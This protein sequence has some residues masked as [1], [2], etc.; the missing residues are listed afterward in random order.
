MAKELEKQN[1]NAVFIGHVDHGKSTLVGRL[2]YE[3][4]Q[5]DKSVIDRYK[6]EAEKAGKATFEYAWVMDDLKEERER[7][8]TIRAQI[9]EFSTS[10][11]K[12][13]ISDAP[14]HKDFISNM[15]RGSRQAD[16]AVIVVSAKEGVQE[17]TREHMMIAKTFG[18]EQVIVA[19]NK[20][21]ATQPPYSREA[22]DLVVKDMS[23]ILSMLGYPEDK[24]S[25]I[26]L[27][28]YY[29]DNIIKPSEN[30]KWYKGGTLVDLLNNLE[31][32]MDFSN[33]PLRWA[34]RDVVK[35]KGIGYIPIGFI[36]TGRM[37]IGDTL[38]FMPANVR[39]AVKSIESHHKQLTDAR[40]GEPVG[41]DIRLIGKWEKQ[42]ELRS[43]YVAGLESSP[44]RVADK[45]VANI[46]IYD[47]P[48]AIHAGYS[49][50]I[51]IHE[52]TVR[53]KITSL[54]KKL[55]ART[56]K[57]TEENPAYLIKGELAEV[58]FKPLLPLV[59]EEFKDNPKLGRFG[60][61]DMGKTI[62]AGMVTKIYERG[63]NEK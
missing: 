59:I 35:V 28:A 46:A 16:A 48:T 56:M 24:V 37:K 11:Y 43:G 41:C 10:K 20:M 1:I 58:T 62:G 19:V 8:L 61:R 63:Q 31:P 29:G 3:T 57:V 55:D 17:Q 27:S 32:S 47:H 38:V 21:D 50:M 51:H 22:Y 53:C 45:F 42:K 33:Y 12:F 49:P 30:M 52:A 23:T 40:A 39:G 5:I 44:P 9:K 18:L 13:T 26:P 15:I 4:G 25:Y 2:L 14:G 34:L 54:D 36:E 7:G 6:A 60:I